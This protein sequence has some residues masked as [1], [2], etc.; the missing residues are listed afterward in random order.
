MRRTLMALAVGFFCFVVL[1]L[2]PSAAAQQA[3]SGAAYQNRC[4]SCH[5]A[6]MTG[7]TGPSILGYVR[8]HTD[9]DLRTA[10][11]EKHKNITVPEQE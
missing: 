3:S 1:A 8:Y 11:M 10:L 6:A 5:G 2:A 9:A 4:S 7:G